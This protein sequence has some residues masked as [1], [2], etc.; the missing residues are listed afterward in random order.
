M[1]P[2][3]EEIEILKMCVCVFVMCVQT[4]IIMELARR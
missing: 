3:I 4:D 1:Y 2:S